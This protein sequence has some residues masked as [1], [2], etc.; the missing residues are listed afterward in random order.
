MWRY[1]FGTPRNVNDHET[2]CG[3][4]GK[5]WHENDGLCGLCGDDWSLP[6]PRPNEIGGKYGQGV[7]AN[8]YIEGQVVQFEVELTAYHKGFFEFRVCPQNTLSWPA[9]QACLD[10][11]VLVQADAGGEKYYPATPRHGG[12]GDRYWMRY[13]LPQGLTCGLCVLQWRYRAGNSWGA[14]SN[15]TQGIGCG[16]QEEF[17]A[18]SDISIKTAD[19]DFSK[20]PN[21]LKDLDGG[22]VAPYQETVR[23]TSQEYQPTQGGSSVLSCNLP[24]VTLFTLFISLL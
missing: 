23:D 3:G 7:L 16:P 1:D 2:N 20:E 4:F 8:S 24:L 18:C 10:Q 15:G 14:C 9:S 12:K 22:R 21:H 5:Q 13:K 17:R 19:G 11:H 6:Q